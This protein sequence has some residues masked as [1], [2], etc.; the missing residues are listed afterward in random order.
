MKSDRVGQQL[1]QSSRQKVVDAIGDLRRRSALVQGSPGRAF[2]PGQ[3]TAELPHGGRD[4][5]IPICRLPG[6]G[7]QLLPRREA[8]TQK[9]PYPVHQ[10]ASMQVLG[11]AQRLDREGSRSLRLHR[12]NC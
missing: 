10:L 6:Q 1:R 2:R 5:Q 4:A 12:Q 11:A 8:A 9:H 7:F 3:G